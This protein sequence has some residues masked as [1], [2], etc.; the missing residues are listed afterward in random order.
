MAD[1]LL[2]FYCARPDTEA[3]VS[4]LRAETGSPVHVSE[5]IVFGR[6]F[7]DAGTAERVRGSLERSA[8]TLIVPQVELNRLA[9]AVA[10]ARRML[11]VRWHACPVSIGG[12]I[13]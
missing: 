3:V 13:A 1:M 11:P 9:T 2:T 12:R 8:V 7:S 6:D 4:T 10:G 5:E